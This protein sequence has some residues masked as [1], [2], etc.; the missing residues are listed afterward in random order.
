MSKANENVRSADKKPEMYTKPDGKRGVRMV[1]VDREI[2]KK[3]AKT[4]GAMKRMATSQSSKPDR[5]AGKGLD[6]YKKKPAEIIRSKKPTYKLVRDTLPRYDKARRQEEAYID[7]RSD[8]IGPSNVG[9]THSKA[10]KAHRDMAAKLQSSHKR[11]D[12]HGGR[13]SVGDVIKMHKNAADQH[14]KALRAHNAGKHSQARNH[15]NKASKHGTDIF[16]AHANAVGDA[17]KHA[18]AGID[19]VGHSHDAEKRSIASKEAQKNQREST[20]YEAYKVGQTVKPTKGPHAG[21]DHEVIHVHGDGSYN[22]KPKNMPASRIR[23]RL[24]AARAKHNELKEALK[25]SDGMGAWIDDFSKSDA[26]QFK[27][28]NKKE[29]RDMAIAAYLSAKKNEAKEAYNEPQGQAKRMM[30]PLHK[31][32]MDKEK[33]DRDSQGKI[34]PGLLKAKEE[35][36]ERVLTQKDKERAFAK[37]AKTA[38]P[39][40]QVSLAKAPFKIPPKDSKLDEDTHTVDIDHMGGHDSNAKKHNITIKKSGGSD[41]AHSATGKKKDLQKYLVKHYDDH[42]T[43]KEIH[44]EVFKGHKS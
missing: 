5:M 23:Y 39:K 16:N 3:D 13:N 30:S 38:K 25:V 7:H 34:K 14:A 29:K 35:L 26:P 19:A 44:P 43:A 6:T 10:E 24:G 41:Y 22:I 37:A 28:K 9:M 40:S 20:V 18:S 15:A 36:G 33:K 27:G 4:E 17:K 31:M 21:Q 32:R 1:A 42:E 8:K 2:V 12:W 11:T